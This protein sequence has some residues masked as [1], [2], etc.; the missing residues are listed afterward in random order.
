MS[1]NGK[2][3]RSFF[4]AFGG[5]EAGVAAVV[6]EIAEVYL[7]D[8]IPWTVGYSGGK[9]STATLQL[10][11]LALRQIGAERAKKPVHV[12]STDTLVENPVVAAWVGNSLEKMNTAAAAEGFPITSH[13]LTPELSDG[14]WVNLIG[15]GYP[16]PRQK[17]RWCT[18]R[19]KI[20]PA[21][22][23]ISSMV[24]Q[25]GETL[26]VLGVR[27]AES[28]ARARTM[29]RHEKGRV[30]DKISPN[31]ALANSFIYS[32]I[33]DWKDRDVWEFLIESPN[34]W[35]Q[36]NDDLFRMYKGASADNEC[37]MVVG[38]GTPSC[39]DS[40]FGCW[41][42][43][44]VEKDK[45]MQAMISNDEEKQWMLPLLKI[46]SAIDFRARSAENGDRDLRD[47]RRM[48]G[49]VQL[50]NGRVIPG[51]YK[52]EFREKLL[53]QVLE[54]QVQVRKSGP[55]YVSD[56]TL[57][58]LAELEEI[59]RIWVVEKHEMEDNLPHIYEE[60]TGEKYPGNQL[61]DGLP[62]GAEE[63]DIL[64][65]LC[66]EDQSQYEMVRELLSLGGQ[67]NGRR[68]H[69]FFQSLQKAVERHL[70]DGEDEAVA[71][72]EERDSVISAT[73]EKRDARLVSGVME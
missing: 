60:A 1:A 57:I 40:R 39:G 62:F 16:A 10:V 29:Q 38:S 21:N 17:F 34:P 58:Q 35:G 11:W 4:D 69:K 52:Q 31:G 48:N 33:E 51:P 18:E 20:R 13:R 70:H 44:L 14:F 59:R 49:R 22:R 30:R 2:T 46:R 71:A 28:A 36:D 6:S 24:D 66:G 61:N 15:R 37:P 8:D 12:I 65:E 68:P 23:F 5:F 27:K 32:P 43:T 64:R 9:D 53:R 45:S 47:Y 41:V 7:E 26:L 56:L 55:D 63:L 42:C 3:G 50:F 54:T 72:L 19:L 25:H 73:E 67:S